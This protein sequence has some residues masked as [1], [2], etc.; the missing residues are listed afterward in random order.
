LFTKDEPSLSHFIKDTKAFLREKIKDKKRLI[1]EGTQGF[2]LSLFHSGFYPYVTSRDTTAAGFLS[3]VGL[4]P[5]DVDDIAL[6]IRSFPIRVGEKNS[7]PLPNEIDWEIITNGSGSTKPI[8]EYTSVTK[9][10]RRVARFDSSIVQQAISTNQPTKIFLN[11]LDYIDAKTKNGT[12]IS[13]RV[14]KF[15]KLVENNLDRKINFLGFGADSVIPNN[16]F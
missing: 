2:G 10:I 15:I 13:H 6:V 7:G 11:H 14:F 16:L 12:H 4:S 8:I 5:I 3:E 1:I 9:K